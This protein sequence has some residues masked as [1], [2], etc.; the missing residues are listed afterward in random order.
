MDSL[1][2]EPEES[3]RGSGRPDPRAPNQFEEYEADFS[4][5]SIPWETL[6]GIGMVIFYLWVQFVA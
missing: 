6:L 5:G 4:G 2:M 1:D 3:S